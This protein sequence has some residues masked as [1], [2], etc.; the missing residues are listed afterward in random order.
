MISSPSNHLL[1]PNIKIIEEVSKL[2]NNDDHKE[3]Q[4][5]L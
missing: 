1:N 3:I 5:M 2:S 4:S